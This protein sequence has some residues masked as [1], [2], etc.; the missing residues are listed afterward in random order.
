ML[1]DFFVFTLGV[2]ATSYGMWL[3]TIYEDKYVI[4]CIQTMKR[5]LHLLRSEPRVDMNWFDETLV[6][7]PND[8]RIAL[9][10]H[11]ARHLPDPVQ[12]DPVVR[13]VATDKAPE[14]I[15]NSLNSSSTKANKHKLNHLFENGVD[16]EHLPTVLKN[17][18]INTAAGIRMVGL[19]SKAANDFDYVPPSPFPDS[20]ERRLT[21]ELVQFMTTNVNTFRGDTVR[22]F[23]RAVPPPYGAGDNMDDIDAIDILSWLDDIEMYS[24]HDC[25]TYARIVRK[26]YEQVQLLFESETC[27]IETPTIQRMSVSVA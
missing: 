9:E 8:K 7:S 19:G 10:N 18:N 5:Q 3:A 2:M 24:Y 20:Y 6:W 15:P 17:I 25:K 26:M 4:G 22:E 27:R 12:S 11:N 13:V 23:I 16:T 1:R 14:L 21:S